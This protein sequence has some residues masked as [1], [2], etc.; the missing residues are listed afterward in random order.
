MTSQVYSEHDLYQSVMN[1]MEEGELE[2]EYKRFAR[3]LIERFK[4]AG[5]HLDMETRAE[6]SAI[7]QR[8]STLFS[9]FQC[10][11]PGFS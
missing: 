11:I 4:A 2:A 1:A 5:A 10:V 6:V 8:L 7:S 3:R 9:A